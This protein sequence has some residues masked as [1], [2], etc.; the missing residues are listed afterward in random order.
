EG[1][2][3]LNSY[4]NVN[5]TVATANKI[6][7]MGGKEIAGRLIVSMSDYADLNPLA[8]DMKRR[9]LITT[10]AAPQYMMSGFGRSKKNDIA[11]MKMMKPKVV[12]LAKEFTDGV[13]AD[14][15]KQAVVKDIVR[16][17]HGR[18]ILVLA[19]GIATKE[20]EDFLVSAGIDLTQLCE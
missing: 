18:E 5:M 16:T 11:A 13:H 1:Y 19:S 14:A 2:L 4:P 6:A 12:R 15:K 8:W 3:I 10:E 20:D 17:L 9:S 7:S